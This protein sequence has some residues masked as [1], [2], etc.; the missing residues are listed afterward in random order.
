MSVKKSKIDEVKVKIQRISSLAKIPNYQHIGD[1]GADVCS[2]LD[3]TIKPFERKAIPTGLKVDIPI[4]Y[5]IQVR[6]RS[7]LAINDGLFVLN[8]P[9]TIDSGFRG[10]IQIILMNVSERNYDVRIGQRIAQLVLKPVLNAI[11][12]ETDS[13]S[14]SPR[15]N[16]GFGSTGEK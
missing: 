14:E 8:S 7:G 1:A 12:E 5:E 15:G 4:G 13:L 3:C 11:F 6:S 2:I 10:E 16:R 9:G